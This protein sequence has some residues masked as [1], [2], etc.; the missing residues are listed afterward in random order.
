MTNGRGYTQTN[1]QNLPETETHPFLGATP[2]SPLA[3]VHVRMLYMYQGQGGGQEG[4][5]VQ[6]CR[7]EFFQRLHLVLCGLWPV[8]L[9]RS[10]G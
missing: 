5:V 2:V 9:S 10:R 4:Q 7:D 8:L 1:T 6:T 3:E